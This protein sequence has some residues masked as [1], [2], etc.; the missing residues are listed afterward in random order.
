M[1]EFR[2]YNDEEGN[3]IADLK[4][5]L[6]SVAEAWGDFSCDAIHDY[7]P[8]GSALEK[9]SVLLEVLMFQWEQRKID[10]TNLK[11][12]LKDAQEMMQI[13]LNKSLKGELRR[14]PQ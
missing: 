8:I 6:L 3:K 4:T 1:R 11:Q 5:E 14:L 10:E 13:K 12:Y 7:V 9:Y 2:Y